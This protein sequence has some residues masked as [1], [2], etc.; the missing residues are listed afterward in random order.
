[1][2]HDEEFRTEK[3]NLTAD[4]WI[5]IL[6]AEYGAWLPR[7]CG[8]ISAARD[9]L[10]DVLRA[11]GY[12]NA[13]QARTILCEIGEHD[14]QGIVSILNGTA[15][16]SMFWT[17]D[18]SPWF[19]IVRACRALLGDGNIIEEARAHRKAEHEQRFANAAIKRAIDAERIAQSFHEAYE[20][21]APSHGYET[22]RAS[23]KQW[24]DVPEANKSLMVATVSE[25]LAH[26]VIEASAGQLPPVGVTPLEPETVTIGVQIN[27]KTIGTIALPTDAPT[28]EAL[29]VALA[30]YRVANRINDAS[31]SIEEYKS[32]RILRLATT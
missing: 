21:L 25:L 18:G 30:D 7:C 12:I 5:G 6:D 2:S 17:R 32:G 28:E 15:D 31:V 29:R 1:M 4:Q 13:E 8:S 26:N 22:R 20:R 9:V 23:A 19:E 3:I 16:G 24:P 27:G 11:G 10:A 14:E